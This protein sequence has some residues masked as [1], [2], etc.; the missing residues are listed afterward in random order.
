MRGSYNVGRRSTRIFGSRSFY[1][2]KRL[3]WPSAIPPFQ[4]HPNPSRPFL[5][6]RSHDF[7]GG[8]L[9]ALSPSTTAAPS[10]PG[11]SEDDRSAIPIALVGIHRG[12]RRCR[13]RR[14]DAAGSEL[15]GLGDRGDAPEPTARHPIHFARRLRRPP[16]PGSGLARAVTGRARA[17]FGQGAGSDLHR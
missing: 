5:F 13:R 9:R 3:I 15:R 16:A 10:K 7:P 8:P 2:P 12:A 11:P 6:R 17:G 14:S 4:L 1:P